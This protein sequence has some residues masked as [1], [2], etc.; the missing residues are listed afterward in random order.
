MSNLLEINDTNFDEEVNKSSLPVLI[1][2]YADWCGPCKLIAPMMDEF[3][4]KFLNRLKICKANMEENSTLIS[5]YGISSVPTLLF[6]KDGDVVKRVV[7]LKDRLS[8]E[9][10]IEEVLC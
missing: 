4:N 6:F 10:N 9:R 8:I 3:S 7:G 1:D 5:R 2:I